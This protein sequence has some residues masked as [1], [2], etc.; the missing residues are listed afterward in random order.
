LI[1]FF[2]GLTYIVFAAASTSVRFCRR[3]EVTVRQIWKV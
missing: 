2:A 3:F 1:V